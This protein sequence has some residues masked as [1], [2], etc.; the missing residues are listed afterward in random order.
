MGLGEWILTH[1]LYRY[2]RHP[3]YLGYIVSFIGLFLANANLYYLVAMPIFFIVLELARA[4]L[5]ERKMAQV[6][7]E[8]RS[9]QQRTP[10]LLP[11]TKRAA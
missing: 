5:E 10:F 3:I 8:Y 1:G 6:S 2:C 7:E 4:V 9:Y 11:F